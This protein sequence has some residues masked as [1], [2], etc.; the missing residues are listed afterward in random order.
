M[1]GFGKRKDRLKN[2]RVAILAADGVEQS[3]L[4]AVV[5]KLRSAGA[6]IFMLSLRPGKLQ[7]MHGLKRG[8]K[9]PVDGAIDEVHPASFGGLFIPG[10][11]ISAERLRQNLR[12][13]EFVRSF[14]RT[15]KP[16]A[17]VG[18]GALV[19]ASAGITSGRTLTAWPGIK[20]DLVNA[21]AGW[22]DETYVLDGNL[23]TSRTSRDIG[24][25]NKQIVDHFARTSSTNIVSA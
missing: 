11:A 12:V 6:E 24:K 9:I 21:G 13:L 20:D 22:A 2:V 19:L 18:H 5:K 14:D 7:A 15:G 4:D 23:L 10:G 1:F 16:I 25:F 8:D 3:Q 17:V